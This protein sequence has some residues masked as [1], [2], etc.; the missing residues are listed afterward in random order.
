[1]EVQPL[2]IRGIIWVSH[3][4]FP[5]YSKR[6]GIFGVSQPIIPCLRCSPL[7][8]LKN[9]NNWLVRKKIGPAHSQ[10]ANNCRPLCAE[11]LQPTSLHGTKWDSSGELTKTFEAGMS[12]FHPKNKFFTKI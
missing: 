8:L 2:W 5:Y 6:V 9:E 7:Q 11:V 3:L 12:P 1:M 4:R 10:N